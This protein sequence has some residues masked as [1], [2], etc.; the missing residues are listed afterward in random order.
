MRT[1]PR[2]HAAQVVVVLDATKSA[3]CLVCGTR[4]VQDGSARR[5]VVGPAVLRPGD[6]PDA[7]APQP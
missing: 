1:C 3:R 5:S 7:A 4:W 2:C 6:A